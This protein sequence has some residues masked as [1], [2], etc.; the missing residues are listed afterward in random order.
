MVLNSPGRGQQGLWTGVELWRLGEAGQARRYLDYAL[1]E[2]ET[3]RHM[4]S[5]D[6]MNELEQAYID[7][8]SL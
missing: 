8:Y 1:E 3:E 7:I 2:I 5:D 4:P 6:E